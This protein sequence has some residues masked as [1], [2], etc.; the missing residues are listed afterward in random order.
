MVWVLT[1]SLTGCFFIKDDQ[2]FLN[3]VTKS[4]KEKIVYGGNENPDQM[5]DDE[6]NKH[7]LKATKKE[8]EILGNFEQ[9]T[10]EDAELRSLAKDYF[11]MLEL[12]QS[13]KKNQITIGWYRQ[14][15]LVDRLHEEYDLKGTGF[16]NEWN[17]LLAQADQVRP[18]SDQYEME[19]YLIKKMKFKLD[20]ENSSG[21]LRTYNASC[22]NF[23]DTTFESIKIDV[24][25]LDQND[26]VICNQSNMAIHLEPGDTEKL[27]FFFL[28]QDEKQKVD[29]IEVKSAN[30]IIKK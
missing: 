20:D 2:A 19:Q 30:A 29:Q 17:H 24:E 14:I 5:S 23:T 1:F 6:Y 8:L 7:F 4:L 12:Q 28:L 15:V 25:F 3:N 21:L 18:M 27:T 22:K 13:G 9:Y 26:N 11:D 16:E 10:F